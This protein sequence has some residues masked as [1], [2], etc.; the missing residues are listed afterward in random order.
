M[1]NILL[2]RLKA[3]GDVV[4]TLPAVH[5]VREN[6]PAARITFLTSKE[7]AP[8]LRGFR[9]VNEVIALDRAA[10]RGGNPLKFFPELAGLLRR[11][12]AG[13]FSLVV[14]FQGYGETA[15]LARLTGAPQRWGSVYGPGRKWAYTRGVTRDDRLQIADLNRSLLQQCGLRLGP[16]RNEFVL[17][18]EPLAAAEKFFRE[19][20]LEPQR[21][22]LFIQAFTS[23][24]GKNWPLEKFLALAEHFRAARRQ[25]IFGCG[26]RETAALRPA[27][28]AGFAV[29]A[30][31]PLLA[32]AG[33]L[34]LSTVTVGGVT[35][36]VHLAVAQQRR[37]VML[38]VGA[39]AT[40]LGLPYQHPD[41]IVAPPAGGRI[42]EVP[43]AAVVAACERA[44]SEPAGSGAC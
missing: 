29:A 30:G 1:E 22:T 9:E 18:A 35:G 34:R 27:Q 40:E 31:L 17:P 7:N 41:W 14:D 37:V 19:Q 38:L 5:A 4:L 26:P 15:W 28:E 10:L 42:A 44:F 20:K 33:L 21:P 11:L 3:I 13:K 6:F 32:A 43:V 24:P 25:V 16:A 36:L 2:I 8:L 39:A 12:R 23:T